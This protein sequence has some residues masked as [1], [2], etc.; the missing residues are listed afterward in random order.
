[1]GVSGASIIAPLSAFLLGWM[2]LSTAC[3]V[4]RFQATSAI[5][6]LGIGSALLTLVL[7]FLGL[8]NSFSGILANLIAAIASAFCIV[9][10]RRRFR[11]SWKKPSLHWIP[12]AAVLLGA[13]MLYAPFPKQSL[14]GERDEGIYLQHA[15]HLAR[16]GSSTLSTRA[17]GIADT[18]QIRAI[19]NQSAPPLPGLYPSLEGWTFQ[20]SSA[21]P[22]WM[23]WLGAAGGDGAALRFNAV[24]GVLN[25]LAFFLLLRRLLP[26]GYKHWALPA[27]AAYA[28]NPVQVWI[29][30]NTLSEPLCTWFALS[31]LLAVFLPNPNPRTKGMLVGALVGMAAF[32]RIDGTVYLSAM[33]SAWLVVRLAR[34]PANIDRMLRW[35]MAGCV[36][37]NLAALAYYFFFVHEYFVQLNS[38]LLIVWAWFLA[39]LALGA[40]VNV[41]RD[42]MPRMAWPAIVVPAAVLALW[43]YG[44][45]VRPHV[46]HFSRIHSELV[47]ALNGMRDYREVTVPNL[48]GYLGLPTVMFAAVGTAWLMRLQLTSRLHARRGFIFFV[49]LI[50]TAIFLWNPLVSPDQIWAARRW[51]PTV[52][53]ATIASAAIGLSLLLSRFSY[54]TNIALSLAFT[55][56]A[57]GSLLWKQRDTLFFKE[58]DGL[59]AQIEAI[60]DFLPQDRPS[61]VVNW[62]T[63]SSALLAG[64]GKPIVPVEAQ[65]ALTVEKLAP[66][67]RCTSKAPCFV[68]HPAGM[69]VSGNGTRLVAKGHLERYRRNTSPLSPVH[70]THPETTS[71]FVTSVVTRNADNR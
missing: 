59:I 13:A 51:V 18:P 19:E 22:A 20:F 68:V 39:A 26:A 70:G 62:P 1:M 52:I 38:F 64:Y 30:R 54:R 29:S 17:L 5:V 40:A 15:R 63:L 34:T 47:P 11:L 42:A 69:S 55:A 37:M 16:T 58:E 48:A 60:A 33:A 65:G 7:M 9:V 32:V 6:A 8:A 56:L 2:V 3:E 61:Y 35:A 67:R 57:G 31:G 41:V 23:A 10:L 71:F 66:D 46:G 27:L 50:P 43:A 45:W 53:P 44:M 4:R 12:A 49:L 24:V 14:L 21:L 36:A 28:L 25:C